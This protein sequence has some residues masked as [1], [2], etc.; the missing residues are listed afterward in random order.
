M[1]KHKHSSAILCQNFILSLPKI[2]AER[3]D[4][5]VEESWFEMLSFELI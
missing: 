5:C 2:K 1:Y 4:D 3:I